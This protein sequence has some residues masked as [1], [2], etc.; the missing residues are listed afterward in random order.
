MRARWDTAQWFAPRDPCSVN[1]WRP[2]SEPRTWLALSTSCFGSAPRNGHELV[3]AARR[4]AGRVEHIESAS[5][6]VRQIVAEAHDD[7][8]KL[9]TVTQPNSTPHG[10]NDAVRGGSPLGS[11]RRS[12][13]SFCAVWGRCGSTRAPELRA[14]AY[15]PPSRTL[16]GV[17]ANQ[18]D[19]C[20]ENEPSMVARPHRARRR[21]DDQRLFRPRRAWWNAPPNPTRGRATNGDTVRRI[22]TPRIVRPATAQPGFG[23]VRRP[24]HDHGRGVRWRLLVGRASR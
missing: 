23:R 2:S 6:V 18:S 5:K 10:D 21:G 4:S 24:A 1:A 17:A 11:R 9:A 8:T 20:V 19:L 7:L 22:S 14:G 15:L 3:A 12:G 16:V 13:V